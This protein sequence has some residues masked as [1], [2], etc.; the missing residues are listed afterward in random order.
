MSIWGFVSGGPIAQHRTIVASYIEVLHTLR[1]A[2]SFRRI[3]GTFLSCVSLL[4]RGDTMLMPNPLTSAC[5][6]WKWK[7]RAVIISLEFHDKPWDNRAVRDKRHFWAT[8]NNC[9]SLTNQ[10][11]ILIKKICEI[12]FS[13]SIIITSAKEVM[14]SHVPICWLVS[15]LIST[16]TWIED[17]SQPRVD[18]INFWCGSR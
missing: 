4:V 18:L 8:N 7:E 14:F 10:L 2:T 5:V 6:I 1:S 12:I 9:K 16:E 17:G 3:K 13:N 15:W 11:V